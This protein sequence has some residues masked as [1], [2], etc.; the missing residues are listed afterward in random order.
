VLAVANE[1]GFD[2]I[3]VELGRRRAKRAR[4]LTVAQLVALANDP[5]P[6]DLDD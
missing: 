2:A 4:S 3:G 1:L 6:A 5:S